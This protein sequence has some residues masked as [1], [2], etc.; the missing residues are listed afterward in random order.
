MTAI[1]NLC[2]TNSLGLLLFQLFCTKH[3][4]C[5]WGR[6]GFPPV[7][8]DSLAIAVEPWLAKSKQFC[9]TN[10]EKTHLSSWMEGLCGKGGTLC[11]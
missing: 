6:G 5:A 1:G 8:V 10:G 2:G 11:I 9:N 4:S 3:H 7:C